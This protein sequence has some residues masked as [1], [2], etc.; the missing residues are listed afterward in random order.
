MIIDNQKRLFEGTY[1]DFIHQ[2]TYDL[3]LVPTQIMKNILGWSFEPGYDHPFTHGLLDYV[4]KPQCHST[5]TRM[6]RFYAQYTPKNLF[7]VFFDS[8]HD[9]LLEEVPDSSLDILTSTSSKTLITPW[10]H[11]SI[12]MGGFADN[13]PETEGSHFLGPVSERH[14]N[15]EYERLVEIY[16]SVKAHGFDVDKQT[17]T[18]RGY[19]LKHLGEF[20]FIVVGGNHRVGVLNALGATHVPIQM[21]PQRLPIV[22][23][24][25][26]LT[27]PQVKNGVFDPR[28]AKAIFL[29]F[30]EQPR[31]LKNWTF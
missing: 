8:L 12:P 16:E 25:D 7:E 29:A 21:H 20:R 15:S 13:M 27:W 23:I 11:E 30:F 22:A 2:S 6:A 14:L 18:I 26:I 31:R 19:F 28:L 9:P 5:D 1:E 17:D 4:L 24:D 10:A 3:M